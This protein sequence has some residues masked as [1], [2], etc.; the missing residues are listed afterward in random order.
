VKRPGLDALRDAALSRG[1]DVFVTRDDSRL[2]GDMLRVATFAQEIIDAGVRIAFYATGDEMLLL[3]ETAR[4]IAV[5]RG[6]A[7]ES[8]RR[9]ISG[10]TRENLER[11][12][13]RGLVAGGVTYGYRNVP[14]PDGSGKVREILP[15]QAAIL[16]EIFQR[17][18]DG[19]GLR[20]IV[21]SL[22]A[23]HI[24]PPRAGARGTG[25]WSQSAI[26]AMLRRPL[27][28]GQA[29]WGETHKMYKAGTKVRVAK[30]DCQKVIV[31]TPHLRIVPEDLWL[32]VRA[33]TGQFKK[34]TGAKNRG[35]A[36]HLLSGLVRCESCKGPM[37]VAKKKDRRGERQRLRLR[38]PP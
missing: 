9:K 18:A 36:A 21:K 32:K 27:Y 17:Y 11:K 10:R 16:R 29:I 13:R 26:F 1:V 2:G 38:L 30:H 35:S 31:E 19:E 23:R 25:S 33:R 37:V 14:A 4:L 7:S 24:P 20:G 12:A 15:E 8:E 6:Y 22:N 28:V 3:T 34:L 5:V